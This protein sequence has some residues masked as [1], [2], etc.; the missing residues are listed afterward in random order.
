MHTLLFLDPGHFHAA[1]TLRVS[2]VRAT[3]EVFVYA[4]EGAELRDF[5]ALV[6]RFNRALRG[7]HAL[8][9]GR[10][11][12]RRPARAARGRATRR[13]GGARGQERGQGAHH[14]TA[15]RLGLPRPRRQAVAR[16]AGR[17]RARAS[18]PR[19][20]APGR[21]DH[22]GASRRGGRARE[23]ARRCSRALRRLPRRRAGHRAGE[24]SPAG[25]ARGRRPPQASLVVLRRARAGKRPGRHS[26][27]RRGPGAVA[28]GGDA[29]APELLSARA[30]STQV[31]AEAFRRIT[32]EAGFPRELEPFV[33]GDALSYRCNAE[34]VYRIGRVTASAATRW[35]LSPTPDGGDASH[36]VAHGTR[37]DIRLEQSA[38][39]GHRR[40]VFSSPAPMPPGSRVHCVTRSRGG[41]QSFPAS[42]SCPQARKRT[43]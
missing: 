7:P 40:R 12:V 28:R 24:R 18:E 32:G 42:R 1:L 14:A 36:S 6:E 35:T 5:L 13:R 39:T 4:H 43:R 2:Q 34:L 19:G 8:A 15:A 10:D 23:E 29:A 21:G 37:A 20:L 31:P 25:E 33:D 16:G 9:S 22:D 30:W 38:R 3:D 17:P 11:D 41:R 26:D 27:P